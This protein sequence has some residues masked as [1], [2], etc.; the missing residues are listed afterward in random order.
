MKFNLNIDN[1]NYVK[2]TYKDNEGF[3]HC[4]KAAIKRMNERE[5]FACAKFEDGLRVTVPQDVELNIASE[6]GLYKANTQLKFIKN[7]APYVFFTLKTPEN[8]DYQ[9]NREYFRVKLSENAT[10]SFG[11]GENIKH[12]SCET[13]DISAN[14]VRLIIDDNT[15]F[16]E[17][18]LL[19]LYLPAKTITT[20]AKFIRNDRE[21]NI[22]KASFSFNSLKDSDMDYISQICFKKQLE[23]RRKNLM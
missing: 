18:V 8:M 14:G 13:Y 6:N 12:I 15:A 9:Q 5:I 16:P 19:T 22:I 17:E 23:T 3:S 4:T 20:E 10:I 11:E 21:D 7:E 2:I 1:I